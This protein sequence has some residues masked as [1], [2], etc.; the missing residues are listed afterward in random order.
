MSK[1]F[2][3]FRLTNFGQKSKSIV[4]A[5]RNSRECED[6]I[7]RIQLVGDFAII[8]WGFLS[9]DYV[10]GTMHYLTTLS[11]NLSALPD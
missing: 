3:H 11:I 8:I 7:C 2:Y 6:I 1:V 9:K 4:M 10:T 5:Q